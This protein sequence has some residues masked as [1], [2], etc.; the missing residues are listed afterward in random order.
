MGR[1]DFAILALLAGWCCAPARSRGWCLTISTGGRARSSFGRGRRS[2]WLPLPADVGE[3]SPPA[4]NGDGR[5]TRSG[6]DRQLP[7]LPAGN[8]GAELEVRIPKLRQGSYF[9][10][11][12]EPRRRSGRA[13]RRRPAGLH[14]RGLPAASTSWWS[15]LGC[16]CPARE[17]C[18]S[19]PVTLLARR[20]RKTRNGGGAFEDRELQGK[21]AVV[22]GSSRGIGLETATRL[23]NNGAS[24]GIVARA[25]QAVDDAVGS[26]LAAAGRAV[27]VPADA[28]S[29]EATERVRER[30]E[31]GLGAVD[32]SPPS[33]AAEVPDRPGARAQRGGVALHR[34]GQ[35]D[36]DVPDVE[37]VLPGMIERRAGSIMTM[38]SSAGRTPTPAARAR[39]RQPKPASSC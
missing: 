25:H 6:A 20:R 39:A 21:V 33:P 18:G 3:R 28:T 27:G 38:A 24:V 13:L 30:I 31:S 37:D 10:S 34:R 19:A 2:E 23:A 22:T 4:C 35:P 36:R 26:I 11:F 32:S 17:L 9:R 16:A 8:S 5:R 15:R 12:L 29:L 14:L 1:R 7:R